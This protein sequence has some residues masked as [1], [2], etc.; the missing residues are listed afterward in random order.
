[1]MNA[2]KPNIV[3]YFKDHLLRGFLIRE[4]S[5]MEEKCDFEL[6]E[7]LDYNYTSRVLERRGEASIVSE[8]KAKFKRL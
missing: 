1:M 5:K 8:D 7:V 2:V 4:K 6:H 3:S